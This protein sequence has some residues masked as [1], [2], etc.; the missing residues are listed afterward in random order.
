M[1]ISELLDAQERHSVVDLQRY[2]MD[3]VDVSW[4]AWRELL[5]RSLAAAGD[6]SLSSL[7]ASWDGSC[8]S[9]SLVAPLST[10]FYPKL[11]ELYFEDE[12]G[13]LASSVSRTAFERSYFAP[14][15]HAGTLATRYD[16]A[17]RAAEHALERCGHKVWGN[18]YSIT[19]RHPMA[20]VPVVGS[21]LGLEKGPFSWSGSPGTLNAAYA[22][23]TS[24][25]TFT[26]TVGVSW[27]F[28]IDFANVDGATM[29]LPAG[30][31]GNPMSE[32]FFDFFEM[33]RRGERWNVP[34]SREAVL[35]RA[36]STLRLVPT[37]PQDSSQA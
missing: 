15:S 18:I 27:R 30:N 35:E 9:A 32:H 3:C 31:S 12:L 34:F 24:D 23:R 25:S 17:Q 19:M 2:Q 37:P 8:D 10:V 28:V 33:Y 13:E 1:R 6:D 20:Q 5:S 26:A 7:V 16:L 36:V 14:T 22:H 11:K 4:M 29:V 21:L